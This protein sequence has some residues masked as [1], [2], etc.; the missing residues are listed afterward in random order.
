MVKTESGPWRSALVT[1]AS[2]VAA[3]AIG[4]VLWQ[5]LWTPQTFSVF[6]GE[7]G[8]GEVAL[9]EQFTADAWYLVVAAP[10]GLAVAVVRRRFGA[11]S[12][13]R[14]LAAAL[15][16]AIAAAYVMAWVGALLGPQALTDP[17]IVAQ[18][19]DGPVLTPLVL[20]TKLAST[21]WSSHVAAVMLAWPLGV[22]AGWVAELLVPSLEPPE[23]RQERDAEQQRR[24]EAE[25]LEARHASSHGGAGSPAPPG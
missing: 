15:L 24:D 23:V 25:W 20:T 16:G 22:L 14:D 1:F 19:A 3:G 13:L 4:G 17:Q 8:L 21:G 12:G 10:L 7:A 11:R 9:S 18:A 5:L 6:L 2:L